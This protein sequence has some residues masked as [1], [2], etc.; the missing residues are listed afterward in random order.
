MKGKCA[1][2]ILTVCLLIVLISAAVLLFGLSVPVERQVSYAADMPTFIISTQDGGEWK[3]LE[4]GVE[5]ASFNGVFF[6]YNNQDAVAVKMKN[7][8]A[9]QLVEEGVIDEEYVS[10]NENLYDKYALSFELPALRTGI[11]G[12]DTNGYTQKDDSAIVITAQYTPVIAASAVGEL[13]YRLKGEHDFE[14]ALS[15]QIG[16]GLRFGQ[17]VPVGVYQV[18]YVAVEEFRFDGAMRKAKSYGNTVECNIVAADA[19][20]PSNPIAQISYGTQA[21]DIAKYI[22]ADNSTDGKW[23]LSQNQTESVFEGAQNISE[24]MLTV[25]ESEYEIKFDFIPENANYLPAKDICVKVSVLPRT[26]NVYIDDAFSLIGEEVRDVNEIKYEFDV[27]QLAVGDSESDLGISLYYENIDNNVAGNYRILARSGNGNYSVACHNMYSQFFDYGRYTVYA[28]RMNVTADDGREFE[29]YCGLGFVGLYAEIYVHLTD[30]VALPS[31]EYVIRGYEIAF[32]DYSGER[33]S[34]LGEY[35]L[36]W[37]DD[38]DG[39]VWISVGEERFEA[40]GRN[41]VTLSAEQ[42]TIWFL[43]ESDIKDDVNILTKKNIALI[44]VCC[45][46]AA[47]VIA[48]AVYWR[49][50]RRLL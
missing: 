20:A 14:Y 29:I 24:V 35:T 15:S 38:V 31:G 13:E 43:G 33:V 48:V 40:K 28:I 2:I 12:T 11:L 23:V 50:K 42:N 6:E 41:S 17:N 27:S 32:L 36:T 21:A 4:N 19:D 49:A 26:V 30:A 1:Q 18:R 34:P 45:I 37:I 8:I 10:Q 9:E 46:L 22:T 16:N 47:S 7:R 25:R 44:C 39:A 3:L 5:I